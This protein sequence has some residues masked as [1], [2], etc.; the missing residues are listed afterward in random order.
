[1]MTHNHTVHFHNA[2]LLDFEAVLL[3]GESI[4]DTTNPIGKFGTGF[5]YA[6]ARLLRAGAVIIIRSGHN[7]HKVW[8][9]DATVRGHRTSVLMLDERPM[10]IS[11]NLGKSWEIWHCYR[12][13]YSNALDE[14]N[15]HVTTNELPD[16]L[17]LDNSTTISVKLPELADVHER[18]GEYFLAHSGKTLLAVTPHGELWSGPSDVIFHKGIAVGRLERATRLTYNLGAGVDLT[19][20]RTIRYPFMVKPVIAASLLTCNDREVVGSVLLAGP[21]YA[22]NHFSAQDYSIFS[23]DVTPGA[24]EAFESVLGGALASNLGE[25]IREF[26]RQRQPAGELRLHNLA[27]HEEVIL[28]EATRLASILEPNLHSMPIRVYSNLGRGILGRMYKGECQL[29]HQ[30][31]AQGLIRIAGTIYEEWCHHHY[32]FGDLERDFQNFLIDRLVTEA[33]RREPRP[34]GIMPTSNVVAAR[35]GFAV[36]PVDIHGVEPKVAASVEM[37]HRSR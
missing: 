1:M 6:M 5:K 2:G 22:E 23:V 4:K 34:T 11:I 36:A 17:S 10:N 29:A 12:E 15:G 25:G 3:M 9:K 7:Y 14:P 16:G 24:A 26:M 35:G 37:M 13:L 21:E 27:P 8:A 18:R 28:G 20:D 33:S 32:R 31:L 30:L 19:E